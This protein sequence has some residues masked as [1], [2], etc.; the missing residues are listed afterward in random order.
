MK[1][2]GDQPTK[3]NRA[4]NELTDEIFEPALKHVTLLA[5]IYQLYTTDFM[6]YFCDLVLCFCILCCKC[7]F[8]NMFLA[9][10]VKLCNI[11]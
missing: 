2:M 9:L 3:Q 4:G 1:Y 5:S 10:T 7:Y 8:F 11:V 6:K